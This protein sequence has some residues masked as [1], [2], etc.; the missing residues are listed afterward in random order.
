MSTS[1][2]ISELV[3]KLEL[4][5]AML[6]PLEINEERKATI[7][8]DGVRHQLTSL[9]KV[10]ASGDSDRLISILL[11]LVPS[12]KDLDA[13]DFRIDLYPDMRAQANDIDATAA[14]IAKPL[15]DA[16]PDD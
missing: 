4:L 10:I 1:E 8:A 13:I 12:A 9:H 11:D 14:R 7:F 5:L 16:L 2:E 6:E 15:I 3:G